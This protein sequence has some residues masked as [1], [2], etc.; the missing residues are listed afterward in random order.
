MFYINDDGDLACRELDREWNGF[1]D[2]GHTQFTINLV[3]EEKQNIRS[4][5]STPLQYTSVLSTYAQNDEVPSSTQCVL[6]EAGSIDNSPRN[7]AVIVVVTDENDSPPIFGESEIVVGYPVRELVKH[8]SPPYL[9]RVEVSSS[10]FF[11]NLLS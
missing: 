7:T 6:I 8:I 3:L 2:I 9:G 4:R 10:C 5:T 11:S 1:N